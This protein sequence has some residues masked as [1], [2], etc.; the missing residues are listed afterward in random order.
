MQFIENDWSTK[1]L[2]ESILLTQAW[3]QSSHASNDAIGNDPSNRYLHHFATRRLESEAIGDAMLS[4]A[5]TLNRK[6]YGAP[7][8][9]Y[10]TAEDEMKRLFS[11]PVDANRRRM[12]YTK[13]TIMEPAKFLAT[14]N[15]P[16]P[17]IPTGVRDITNTPAQALTLLNHPFTIEIARQWSEQVIEDQHS[18]PRARIEVMLESA[19]S[20]SISAFE[21]SQWET[22][23]LKLSDLRGVPED[24]I[25]KNK[26]L[27]SDIAHTIFNTKEFIYLR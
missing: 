23:L 11:G 16:D 20:R 13:V 25:M 14:F 27:W 4:V 21:L 10:R 3:Q 17:K 24:A 7:H 2:V 18:E 19:F 26:Q 5:G 9:P 15:S 6:M 1:H 22:T 8:N 12:I